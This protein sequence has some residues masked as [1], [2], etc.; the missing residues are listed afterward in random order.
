M[1]GEEAAVTLTIFVINKIIE[2][3]VKYSQETG[4]IPTY[5]ELEENNRLTGVKIEKMMKE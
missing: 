4:K 2:E 3:A 1:A 5:E